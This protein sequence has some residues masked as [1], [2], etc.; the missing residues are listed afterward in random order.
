[1]KSR[2]A[3]AKDAQGWRKNGPKCGNCRHFHFVIV[4]NLSEQGE[5]FEEANLRCRIGR[6]D[7]QKSNWCKRH[8]FR[9]DV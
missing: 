4:R 1:M 9:N 5:F 6:F 3:Q 2:Q 7:T 8:T